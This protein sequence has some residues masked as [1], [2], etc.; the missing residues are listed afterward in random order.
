MVPWW[1]P[2][3]LSNILAITDYFKTWLVSIERSFQG[4]LGAVKTVGIVKELM[5]IWLNEV[6]DTD[7][8]GKIPPRTQVK[9]PKPDHH[10]AIWTT[11]GHWSGSL[12]CSHLEDQLG[13]VSEWSLSIHAPVNNL[14]PYMLY[15][16]LTDPSLNTPPSSDSS[17]P[18]STKAPSAYTI[19]RNTHGRKCSSEN[20]LF[21]SARVL[22][23]QRGQPS[24]EGLPPPLGHLKVNCRT[25]RGTD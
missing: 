12:V 5:E 2:V 1:L 8:S 23:V 18:C 14:G 22:S 17:A 9:C 7:P 25:K 3:D 16:F 13:A 6:C 10:N 15:P 4:L 20:M 19:W 24:C 11:C 21:T